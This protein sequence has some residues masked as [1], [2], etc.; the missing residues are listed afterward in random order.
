MPQDYVSE[1]AEQAFRKAATDKG[2]EVQH[3]LKSLKDPPDA[4][5]L[6]NLLSSRPD[7]QAQL[8]SL[9]ACTPSQWMLEQELDQVE[10]RRRKLGTSHA[11]VGGGFYTRAA[12][13][14]LTGLCF[15][16]GGI[17]SATFNLGILQGLAEL[18]LLRCFDYLSSVSGG[19]YIHQWLAAWTKRRSFEEVEK[20]LIPL[21]EDENPG[22]HPEP[23]RWLRRYSNY[24]TPQKG[25]LTA[26]TW[27][28]FSIWLR[29]TLLNQIVLVSGLLFTAILLHVVELSPIVPHQGSGIAVASGIGIFLLLT[30]TYFLGIN[31]RS[32]SKTD[33]KG[34]SEPGRSA[35]AY[36][37]VGVQLSIVLPFISQPFRSHC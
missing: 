28:A 36:G 23:I 37:Q 29:N 33:R 12:A 27:V 5:S 18:K 8:A 21:P 26:D 30:A 6:A 1:L 9:T 2:R 10:A 24:L 14:R 7:L 31:L 35:G 22:S 13:L 32:W 17:R 34:T 19:G 16:G 4:P 15:S 25:L 11:S 20:Q 3:F